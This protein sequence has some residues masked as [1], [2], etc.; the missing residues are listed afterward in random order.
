MVVPYRAKDVPALRAEFGHPD[1][2][3]GLTCLNYY[4]S[5]LK[6]KHLDILF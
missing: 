1:I 2:A 6:D 4:Y 3:I 5:G